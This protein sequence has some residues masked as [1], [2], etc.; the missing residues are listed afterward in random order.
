MDDATKQKV[1][2]SFIA[3]SVTVVLYQI[4]FNSNQFSWA[5][6]LLK[7]F[8]PAAVI[9]GIVFGVMHFLQR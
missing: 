6:L 3:F 1:M 8:L 7:G 9:A 4:L 5:N 2:Y